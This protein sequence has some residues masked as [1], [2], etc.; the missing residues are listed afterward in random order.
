MS[1]NKLALYEEDAMKTESVM[2]LGKDRVYSMDCHKTGRNNN[3]LV[4]GASGAGKTRGIVCPNIMEARGS[5][6]VSDP[7]GN[8][9]SK[10]KGYLKKRGYIV[11][12]LDFTDPLNSIH[13]NFLDYIR[14][15]KDIIKASHMLASEEACTKDPFWDQSA[16]MLLSSL[17]AYCIEA[18]PKEQRNFKTIEELLQKARRGDCG[19]SSSSSLDE[20]MKFNLR[21]YPNSWACRQF[22]NVNVAPDRTFDSILISLTAKLRN[23]NSEEIAQMMS[24]D[25]VDIASIGRKKTALFVVVSD[26]DRSMDNLANLF[27]TQA[28]NE[29]CRFADKE[30]KDN[31]LPVPVRFILDDFATNCRIDEFPRMI[32]SIRSRNISAMLM[33]QAEAQLQDSYGA[34]GR[35]IISNCDTYIY[36]GGGDIET[37]RAVAERCD[38]PLRRIL[39]MEVGKIIV[40][41]RGEEPVFGENLNLSEYEKEK[42]FKIIPLEEARIKDSRSLRE[43]LTGTS[44]CQDD[45]ILRQACR[46]TEEMEETGVFRFL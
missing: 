38:K 19:C 11:K 35:T 29:L 22:A 15:P 45:V 8:L 44:D 27:F 46:M 24:C 3:V 40:L 26:T 25:E 7:K 17:I 32:S 9:Y 5:Y 18:L 6:I 33:I 1:D 30:C 21:K 34:D 12:K 14:E 42:G 10:Y 23:Y 31:R 2:I 13:Y 43:R 36:M 20:L 4:V 41:R 16:D 39:N 37:A 28:M